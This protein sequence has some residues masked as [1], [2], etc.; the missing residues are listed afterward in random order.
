MRVAVLDY[1]MGNLRSVARAIERVGGSPEISNDADQVSRADALVVPGVGNFGACVRN[2]ERRGLA[3]C[4][5]RAAEGGRPVLAICVGMQLLFE[6]SDE[7]RAPGLG[8]L[9]GAVRRL[10]AEVKVP[11]MGWN[12]VRWTGRHPLVE[13]IP[14][15]TRFYFVHSYAPD[16]SAALTVG[17]TEHGRP[18]SAAVAHG[19]VFG[20]QFHPEKSGDAG[21]VIYERF[22]REAA[23]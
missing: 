7:D 17:V 18:F 8:L 6:S 13:G 15:G 11:H 20:T 12:T 1:G 19:S 2:L 22:V 21:L 10:P 14:S 3:E 9:P 5:R 16:V 23:A 4:V